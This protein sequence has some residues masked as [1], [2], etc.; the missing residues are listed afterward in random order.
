MLRHISDFGDFKTLE[1]KRCFNAVN[2]GTYDK[3][4]RG[5]AI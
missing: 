1:L 4:L 5:A 2:D 3:S